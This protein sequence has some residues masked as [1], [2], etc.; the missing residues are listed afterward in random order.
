MRSSFT[1]LITAEV[2]TW[3]QALEWLGFGV[4][5]PVNDDFIVSMYRVK[6]RLSLLHAGVI[7][8]IAVC[9]GTPLPDVWTTGQ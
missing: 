7:G 3:Q 8:F 5:D 4:D 6:V 2:N 1:A 9:L